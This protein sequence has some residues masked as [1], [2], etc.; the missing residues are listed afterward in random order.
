MKEI[1]IGVIGVGYWG[2]NYVRIFS[3]MN[4]LK[5]IADIDHTKKIIAD[6]YRTKFENDYKK[7]LPLV[8]A[9]VIVT[10]PKLHYRVAKDCLEMG[11]HVLIEK[12]FVL[13]EGEANDLISVARDNSKI[14]MVGHVFE[15]NSAVNKI[16]ELISK[17]LLGDIYYIYSTRTNLGIVR[18]DV[19]AMWNFAPHDISIL[20]YL[21]NDFPCEVMAKGQCYLQ[22]DI[23]DVV[24]MTITF[25]NNIIAHIH[26]SWL[27]PY[28][29]RRMTFVGS[30]K[31]LVYDDVSNEEQIK[32][33]DKG[34][35]I[36]KGWDDFGDFR[37]KTRFGDITVPSFTIVEP[38]KIQCEHFL[39]CIKNNKIPRSDGRSG[40]KVL[41]V[42]SAA[43]KSL[44]NGGH[45]V[46]IKPIKE[47]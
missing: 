16:K 7:L 12:P 3:D 11:K 29:I 43:Q 25:P 13:D 2:K 5:G 4:C 42:L 17:R 10:P 39:E 44:D 8:D 32:I 47:L 20:L 18:K 30:E 45:S 26:V 21:I 37:F 24:F 46:K 6:K 1:N 19:N 14:L 35:I 40:L 27:D 9:V 41:R 31:M 22:K 23:E 38:L 33:Y 15:Y 36:D 28:K 34:I